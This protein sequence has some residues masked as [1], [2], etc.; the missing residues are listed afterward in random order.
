MVKIADKTSRLKNGP[1]WSNF[2]PLLSTQHP[3]WCF[4]AKVFLANA[5]LQNLWED[6]LGGNQRRKIKIRRFIKLTPQN[7][8][9]CQHFVHP[10]NLLKRQLYKVE[11]GFDLQFS[12]FDLELNTYQ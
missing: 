2:S 9:S 6:I 7:H 8:A 11:F 12:R 10:L 4:F 1:I 3:R 5:F